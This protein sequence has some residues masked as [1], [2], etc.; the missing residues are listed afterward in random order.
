MKILRLAR[1]VFE[2]NVNDCFREVE[3]PFSEVKGVGAEGQHPAQLQ[4]SGVAAVCGIFS[5]SEQEREKERLYVDIFCVI[6]I[7]TIQAGARI[8]P[9]PKFA[10][11]SSGLVSE[12]CEPVSSLS[13]S[14][15]LKFPKKHKC[16]ISH[17]LSSSIPFTSPFHRCPHYLHP[18]KLRN[19]PP[20]SNLRSRCLRS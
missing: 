8:H 17:M 16:A 9:S 12:E 11:L 4:A 10:D 20:S 19:G 5:A 6:A 14:T 2:W 3:S 13:F 18:D 1:E 15:A 7:A